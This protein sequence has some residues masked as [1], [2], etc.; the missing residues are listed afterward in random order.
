MCIILLDSGHYFFVEL[1]LNCHV[2]LELH[3]ESLVCVHAGVFL[4]LMASWLV[5]A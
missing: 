2:S 1:L 5:V 3:V 4:N